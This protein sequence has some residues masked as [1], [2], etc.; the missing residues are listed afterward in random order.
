MLLTLYPNKEIRIGIGAPRPVPRRDLGRS[1]LTCLSFKT[2]PKHPIPDEA[3]APSPDEPGKKASG[4]A[5]G[6]GLLPR[7]RDFSLYA[8]RTIARSGGCFAPA[9]EGRLVFLT[10]TLPGCTEDAMRSLA[11]WSSWAVNKAL[12]D[13]SRCVGVPLRELLTCWVWEYQK[14]GALH[15][16][17]AVELPDSTLALQLMSGFR[18]IWTSVLRGVDARVDCDIFERADGGSW[19]QAPEVWRIDAQIALSSPSNYLA[20]YLSKGVPKGRQQGFYP[21]TRWYQCSRLL[22]KRLRDRTMVRWIEPCHKDPGT[23]GDK[24]LGVIETVIGCCSKVLAFGRLF[25]HAVTIVGYLSREG[26]NKIVDT[27]FKEQKALDTVKRTKLVGHHRRA[28]LPRY[29]AAISTRPDLLERFFNDIGEYHKAAFL[30][31][32]AGSQIPEQTAEYLDFTAAQILSYAGYLERRGTA[33]TEGK[34]ACSETREKAGSP[35]GESDWIEQP[36]LPF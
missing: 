6:Y 14:R 12:R 31:L 25:S 18:A 4:F 23:V 22:L 29:L 19:S 30:R 32:Y 10:G 28:K 33:P 27:I 16:H 24:E 13:I 36:G 11:E 3:R 26:H 34:R 9:D 21:P 1:A 35:G 17:C 8:R 15:W 2:S 20:K 7:R 5:P